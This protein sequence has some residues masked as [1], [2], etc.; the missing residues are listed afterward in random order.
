MRKTTE[1]LPTL[2][3]FSSKYSNIGELTKAVCSDK[4]VRMLFHKL[5]YQETKLPHG[6]IGTYRSGKHFVSYTLF[7]NNSVCVN[8]VDKSY[9]KRDVAFFEQKN[10][11]AFLQRRIKNMIS[12]ALKTLTR[13]KRNAILTLQCLEALGK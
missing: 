13:N 3:E 9:T 11:H 7:S 10:V 5:L 2:K 6:G 1:Q 8:F 12:E 4:A